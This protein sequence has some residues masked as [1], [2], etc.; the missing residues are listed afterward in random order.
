[1]NALVGAL[2]KC[3]SGGNPASTGKGGSKTKD[4][5]LLKGKLAEG[6]L[7]IWDFWMPLFVWLIEPRRIHRVCSAVFTL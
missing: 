6:I 7:P 1:M 2:D 4:P 5:H 3:K